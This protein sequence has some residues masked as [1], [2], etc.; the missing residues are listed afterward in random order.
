MKRLRTFQ[1]FTL[2][3]MWL[4]NN[5]Q[6]Q[7][8]VNKLQ[9]SSSFNITDDYD[10]QPHQWI[11][12]IMISSRALSLSEVLELQLKSHRYIY[13]TSDQ[14]SEHIFEKIKNFSDIYRTYCKGSQE[15]FN[16]FITTPNLIYNEAAAELILRAVLKCFACKV[17]LFGEDATEYNVIVKTNLSNLPKIYL[18]QTLSASYVSLTFRSED[19]TSYDKLNIQSTL[20]FDNLGRAHLKTLHSGPTKI[21]LRAQKLNSTIAVTHIN[22]MLPKLKKEME[23]NKKSAFFVLSDN[24]PDFN[25]SAL[26]NT[27]YCYR[28]FRHLR[29]DMLSVWTYAARYSAFNPI[30]H[31]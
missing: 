21:Y 15:E 30:E 17:V 1:T 3:Y 14:I 31:L 29:M 25:P 22:D 27:I 26:I 19:T 20:V 13:S 24:G 11:S 12:N 6:N 10:K 9:S 18:Q 4:Q 23:E 28:L 8:H 16:E 5:P 7:T 2:G